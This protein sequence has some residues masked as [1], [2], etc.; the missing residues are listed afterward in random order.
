MKKHLHLFSAIML[1][2]STAIFCGCERK[3]DNDDTNRVWVD[4]G[5]PSGLL[6]ATRNIGAAS[7][8]DYGGY[9]AWGET[10][11]K[12]VYN[13]STYRYA[14]VD[15]NGD[16]LA[17]TK[18][19]TSSSYGVVDNLTTLQPGDD[20]A[21]ANWGGG[22]RTPTMAEW[23]EL[24]ASTISQWTTRNGVY[25]RLFTASNGN[26]LFLPA[27]GVRGDS[28]LLDTGSL[29]YYWSSSLLTD[30]PHYAWY[31]YFDS[32]DQYMY[33]YGYYRNVGFSVRAV[34]QN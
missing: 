2:L 31:F 18:Y 30:Y 26:S 13:W 16:L 34:R 7:P 33:D 24:I 1:L 10:Q 21:T 5:L 17:L 23:E 15:G 14:T 12:S 29:G 22:A 32:Y 4:L 9:F 20:A 19:N 3:P 28:S 6:W 25:G 8:E 27:A 11:P